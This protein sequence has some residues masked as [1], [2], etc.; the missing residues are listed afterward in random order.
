MTFLPYGRGCK[1]YL[2]AIKALYDGSIVAY[3]ISKHN[4]NPL[5][6]ENLRKAMEANPDATPIIHS[7]RGSQYTSRECWMV[8]TQCQMTRSRSRVGKCI[9]N[10]PIESVFGHF[11]TECYDLKAY[12][13][14]EELVY[15]I[16]D[17]IYF[18]NNERFQEKHNSLAPLELRGKAVA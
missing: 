16:D 13:T 8:T 5:V 15:D 9:D 11:K 12:K 1:A 6:M 2:S 17:Y 14:F 10:A 7:D 4:D 3:P 18:Y